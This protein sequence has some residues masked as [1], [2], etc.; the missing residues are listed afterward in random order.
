ML[1]ITMTF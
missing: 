1:H